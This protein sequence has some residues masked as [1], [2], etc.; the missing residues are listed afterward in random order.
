[1]P[2]S[3]TAWLV[4]SKLVDSKRATVCR[5]GALSLLATAASADLYIDG[6]LSLR[7]QQVE[8]DNGVNSPLNGI[9]T[10][11]FGSANLRTNWEISAYKNLSTQLDI[12]AQHSDLSQPREQ[13]RVNRASLEYVNGYGELPFR[14]QAGDLY[15][16]FSPRLLRR[17]LK[18]ALLDIQTLEKSSIQLLAGLNSSAWNEGGYADRYTGVSWL[19]ST[20]H[21]GDLALNFVFSEDADHAAEQR[22]SSLAWFNSL[23]GK[24]HRI[25]WEAEILHQSNIGKDG[26]GVFAE[27]NIQLFDNRTRIRIN[28]ERYN[29]HFLPRGAVVT[30]GEKRW[31]ASVAQRLGDSYLNLDVQDISSLTSDSRDRNYAASYSLSFDNG[32]VLNTQAS[33]RVS[34]GFGS[35]TRSDSQSLQV[36]YPLN[37]NHGINA[38]WQGVD[39]TTR[40]SNDK[41]HSRSSDWHVGSRSSGSFWGGEAYIA[42]KLVWRDLDSQ[43]LDSQEFAPSL[44]LGFRKN[45][46]DLQ[47]FYGGSLREAEPLP[48]TTTR[49]NRNRRLSLSYAFRQGNTDWRAEVGRFVS[50]SNLL[51]DQ[52]EDSV[53]L[54]VNHRFSVDG[55][56]RSLQLPQS[57]NLQGVIDPILALSALIARGDYSLAQDIAR[58]FNPV[59]QQQLADSSRYSGYFLPNANILQQLELIKQGHLLDEAHLSVSLRGMD[60]KRAEQLFET[61]NAYLQSRFGAPHTQQLSGEFEPNLQAALNSGQLVRVMQWQLGGTELRFGL[62]RSADGE[63]KLQISIKDQFVSGLT[64]VWHG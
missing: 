63:V 60:G 48:A 64:G 47:V 1:M 58:N 11:H 13:V 5:L 39:S 33:E 7:S 46:H 38:G 62:P 57:H 59:S 23:G 8:R 40:F 43:N 27:S 9:E 22:S 12:G 52:Q 42:P 61:L 53:V 24:Q 18:G 28:F 36:N 55:Q 25:E 50:H 20:S 2:M 51:G 45:R 6:N 10:N 14:L 3:L 21:L 37:Q 15:A 41:T 30:P 44:S 16:N 29:E 54:S 35:H 56:G 31:F 49:R 17:N 34:S 26:Q 32:L 4:H 19:T